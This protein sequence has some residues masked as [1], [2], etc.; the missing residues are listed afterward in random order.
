MPL[1]TLRRLQGPRGRE[2]LRQSPPQCCLPEFR[3]LAQGCRKF[4]PPQHPSLSGLDRRAVQRTLQRREGGRPALMLTRRCP[5][6]HQGWASTLAFAAPCWQREYHEAAVLCLWQISRCTEYPKTWLKE[7]ATISIYQTDSGARLWQKELALIIDSCGSH[8]VKYWT[9]MQ[10][11]FESDA[12][13]VAVLS[14]PASYVSEASVQLHFCKLVMATGNFAFVSAVQLCDVASFT[15]HHYKSCA[16]LAFS[17]QGRV[18][19]AVYR[20]DSPNFVGAPSKF[21]TIITVVSVAPGQV[22]LAGRRPIDSRHHV[23]HP[24]VWSLDGSMVTAACQLACV[25]W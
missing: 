17:H 2:P 3:A 18:L 25:Y 6:Q 19:A 7:S 9:R 21:E 20:Q 14:H 10:W 16:E 12:L 11:Y 5:Q 4:L 8:V 23:L 1:L 13:T 24:P 22:L 15:D